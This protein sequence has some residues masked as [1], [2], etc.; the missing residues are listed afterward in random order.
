LYTTKAQYISLSA[1]L[2]FSFPSVENSALSKI[3]FYQKY[4]IL[5]SVS[6]KKVVFCENYIRIWR[7]FEKELRQ[8]LLAGI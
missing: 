2:T 3:N 7:K 6:C 4:E 8:K 1:Q 5:K